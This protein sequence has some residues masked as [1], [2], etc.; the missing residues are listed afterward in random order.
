[1]IDTLDTIDTVVI[2]GMFVEL[3]AVWNLGEGCKLY[4]VSFSGGLTTGTTHPPIGCP[5]MEKWYLAIWRELSGAIGY[6]ILQAGLTGRATPDDI[7]DLTEFELWVNRQVERLERLYGL[8]TW[9]AGD[10]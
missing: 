4:D 5:T 10:D 9:V 2:P 8:D 3:C 1:M 6:I 7:D